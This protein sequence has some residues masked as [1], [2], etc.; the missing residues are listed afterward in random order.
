MK[1]LKLL[2]EHVEEWILIVTYTAMLIIASAQVFFRYVINYSISWSQD[3]L[4]YM[5]IWS[6]FIGISLAVKKR[7]HI[8]VELAFVILP[9]KAQFFLKVFSNLVFMVF[10]GVFSY[11]SLIKVYKLIFINPQ[12][13]ESTGLSMWLIQIAVPIGFILSIYRL[14]V[15]TR[16]LFQE[17]ADQIRIGG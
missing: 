5:L 7:K 15:D 12:I 6:V 1:F 8:K 13:S 3:L 9:K 4:T 17:R 16:L 14:V 10:C 2:D 11:F